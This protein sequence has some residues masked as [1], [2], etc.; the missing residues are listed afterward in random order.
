MKI[1]KYQLAWSYGANDPFGFSISG[2]Y[3][4][5]N[6]NNTLDPAL[7][8][9]KQSGVDLGLRFDVSPVLTVSPTF[10]HEVVE[11]DDAVN[12]KQTTRRAGLRFQ[13]QASSV[14]TLSGGLLGAEI[15]TE[16]DGG[17]GRAL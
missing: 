8:D 12:T 7:E 16:V 13:Y 5:Q 15:E 6:F 2:F 4:E 14:V 17:G 9:S 11:D 3:S 1:S 10:S